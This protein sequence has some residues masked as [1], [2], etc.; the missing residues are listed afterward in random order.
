MTKIIAIVGA[1]ATLALAAP[2][3]AG[4]VVPRAC[5]TILPSSI[6][7]LDSAHPNTANVGQRFT[8]RRSG[9]P[10]SSVTN[11]K[12]SA[13]TFTDIPAGATGCT[14]QVNVPPL[15]TANQIAWGSNQAEFWTTNAWTA[16]NAP[17]WSNP[18]TRGQMV[19]T[20][21]FPTGVTT[22]STQQNLASNTCSNTMSFLALLSDWQGAEGQVD[23]TQGADLG[24]KLIYNC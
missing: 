2:S 12:I 7:V 18:P 15:T 11:K 20:F 3:P 23:F 8:L 16:A 1:L 9:S 19:S 22:T 4:D 13:F 21:Q 5:T 24:F 6:D 17:T 14:L 10:G